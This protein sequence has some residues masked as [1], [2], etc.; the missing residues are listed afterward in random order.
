LA[1]AYDEQQCLLLKKPH[2]IDKIDFPNICLVIIDEFAGKYRYE[3]NEAYEWYNMFDHL[4]NAVIAGQMNVLITC[5]K[6]KLDKCINEI[7]RHAI[8]D[9]VVNVQLQTTVVKS[10]VAERKLSISQ[11]VYI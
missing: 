6:V 7:G 4:Y 8:L 5:E 9:H 2:D 1:S 10:E 3:E 11:S